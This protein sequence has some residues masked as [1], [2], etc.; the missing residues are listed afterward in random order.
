MDF[1]N[2]QF[3][4]EHHKWKHRN[5]TYLHKNGK[6]EYMYTQFDKRLACV[7]ALQ[8]ICTLHI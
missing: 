6:A 7:A 2:K 8:S 1:L 5:I 4:Y 3:L